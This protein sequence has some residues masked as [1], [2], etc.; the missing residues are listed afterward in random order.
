MLKEFHRKGGDQPFEQ[1]VV[2]FGIFHGVTVWNGFVALNS[3]C[4]CSTAK[5]PRTQRKS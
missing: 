2:G 1:G 5:A 3:P 4:N